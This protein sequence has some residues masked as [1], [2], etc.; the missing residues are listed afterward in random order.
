MNRADDDTRSPGHPPIA[1]DDVSVLADRAFSRTT[2]AEAIGGNAVRLLIDAAENYPAWLEAIRSARRTILFESYIVDNDAIGREFARALAERARA[3]V[4]VKILVDW[5]GGHRGR[6]VWSLVAGSGAIV[7][8]FNPPGFTSP[9]AWLARDHRKTLTVDGRIGFVSGLCVSHAWQGNPVRRM[10][11]WRDTGL[12][13]EGPAVASLERAFA[14]VWDAAGLKLDDDLLVDPAQVAPAGA[15]KLRVVAGA[16]NVSGTYRLDLTIASVAR[17]YLWLTDAYFV[18]TSAYVQA[19]AAAARDGTDVRLLVPG[20]SDIPMLSPVSRAGYRALL[21]AGVRV[22]EWNGTMLHAK[23]AVADD[24]WAR[25]GST[26]LNLASWMGN[27]ELDVAIE[28]E[29]F[30]AQLAYQYEE[31]LERAT[32][33]VL[34]RRNS[35]SGWVSRA[36]RNIFPRSDANS[37]FNGSTCAIRASRPGSGSSRSPCET[38]ANTARSA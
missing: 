2:G 36:S 3:G 28:D 17:R 37:C 8:M 16:P 13:I 30:A 10:E 22:F 29:A 35:P 27:Y 34:T 1:S 25:V 5:L 7:R 33:I 6:R 9:L 31:D 4:R 20:A 14:Q 21:D 18:G 32:E 11:P 15:V 24:V 38:P 26:N 23:T 12:A 19:L